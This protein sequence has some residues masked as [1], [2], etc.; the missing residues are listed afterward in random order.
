MNC[1]HCKLLQSKN[2]LTGAKASFGRGFCQPTPEL[3]RSRKMLDKACDSF[4]AREEGEIKRIE[5]WMKKN[6]I[7][8]QIL[9]AA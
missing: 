2:P 9:S 6:G 3:T 1:Y 7:T 5:A 4:V 8:A